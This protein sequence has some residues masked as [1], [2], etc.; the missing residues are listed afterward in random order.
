MIFEEF[1]NSHWGPFRDPL[2]VP[3]GFV[4]PMQIETIF[5]MD[6]VSN[7]KPEVPNI[8]GKYW[9]LSQHWP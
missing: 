5:G 8:E 3:K 2:W 7:N 4:K 9:K 6:C 1:T